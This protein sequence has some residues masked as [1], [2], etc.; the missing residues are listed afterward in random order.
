M[1]RKIVYISASF[2]AGA[3]SWAV[4]NSFDTPRG[5]FDTGFGFSIEW[6]E[7]SYCTRLPMS[8][9]WSTELED[10]ARRSQS[11]YAGCVERA[12]LNDQSLV[13]R[14]IE[15]RAVAAVSKSRRDLEQE[16]Y[17][18]KQNMAKSKSH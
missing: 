2:L 6:T 16:I 5:R 12:A 17:I 13:S 18:A 4:A 9:L 8:Y 11:S 14:K 10:I 7:P 3:G 1:V 15:E